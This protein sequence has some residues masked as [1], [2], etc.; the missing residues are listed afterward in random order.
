MSQVKTGN[1]RGAAGSQADQGVGTVTRKDRS[2]LSTMVAAVK[3]LPSLGRKKMPTVALDTDSVLVITGEVA[4]ATR[5]LSE[6]QDGA[7]RHWAPANVNVFV[8]IDRKSRGLGK[9]KADN[10][11]GFEL[12]V[13]AA[14]KR[15]FHPQPLPSADNLLGTLRVDLETHSQSR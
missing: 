4:A 7:L 12:G 8:N 5:L 3:A 10:Y 1:R 14:R 13:N 11:A 15:A 6:R 9:Q 2:V